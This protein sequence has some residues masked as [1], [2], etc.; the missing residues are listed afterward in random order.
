MI[1]LATFEFLNGRFQKV[2][3]CLN[4]E[5]TT[6]AYPLAQTKFSAFLNYFK[7][8]F[9]QK[10]TCCLQ[11]TRLSEMFETRERNICIRVHEP[12]HIEALY[13]L[14]H[15]QTRARAYQFEERRGALAWGL[16]TDRRHD[17]YRALHTWSATVY[18]SFSFFLS[19]ARSPLL[20]VFTD[21]PSRSRTHT[22][23]R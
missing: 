13:N 11:S 12:M 3:F 21:S 9:T 16:C 10:Q 8:V 5:K 7:N 20:F 14:I 2:S 22:R 23:S 6:R 15:R 17:D 4:E 18:P 1:S 19:L